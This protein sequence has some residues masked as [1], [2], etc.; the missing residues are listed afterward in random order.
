QQQQARLLSELTGLAE[1]LAP[2]R[3]R[4]VLSPSPSTTT[5][6]GRAKVLRAH[7]RKGPS[8]VFAFKIGHFVGTRLIADIGHA[9]AASLKISLRDTACRRRPINVAAAR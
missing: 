1:P 3:P 2:S 4:A 8:I 9:V 6:T 5:R 7:L